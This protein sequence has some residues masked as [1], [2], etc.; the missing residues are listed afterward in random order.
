MENDIDIKILTLTI[1]K[2][3]NQ[4]DQFIGA[5]LDENGNVHAPTNS[6]IMKAR[7]CLPSYCKH[8]FKK[9]KR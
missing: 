3:S 6:D 8:A 2:L 9:K 7:A 1:E 4:F 5:C